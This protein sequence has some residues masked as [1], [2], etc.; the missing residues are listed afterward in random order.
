M[1]KLSQKD[2]N[3]LRLKV[4]EFAKKFVGIPY[5]YGALMAE[6]P[7]CFD[8]SGFVKYVFGKKGFE[9]P[10]STIQQAEFSGKKIGDIRKILPGDLMFYRSSS[11][12]FNKKF[13]N[14]IGHVVIYLGS[15]RAIHAKS[16]RIKS[17]P[18]I[19][20]KGSVRID[21]IDKISKQSNPLI[22]I[23]RII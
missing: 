11:G 20:E 5:K 1:K 12:H 8:C 14:G 21:S 15:N 3:A 17:N 22:I 13:P 16:N 18:K 9:I 10:R 6:A 19:I 4:V 23:K 2:K 7:K